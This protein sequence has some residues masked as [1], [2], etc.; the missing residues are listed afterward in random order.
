MIF[1]RNSLCIDILIDGGPS[2]DKFGGYSTE[3]AYFRI[4]DIG[5]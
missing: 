5:D 2:H 3:Y 4:C 1:H